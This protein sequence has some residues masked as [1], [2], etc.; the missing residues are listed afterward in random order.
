M[1]QRS[2]DNQSLAKMLMEI[3]QAAV[4]ERYYEDVRQDVHTFDVTDAATVVATYRD[5]LEREYL[6]MLFRND[7]D[8]YFA[9]DRWSSG[10]DAR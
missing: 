9:E 5:S 2:Y 6:A 10:G 1:T 3:H 7:Q 4:A 8:E